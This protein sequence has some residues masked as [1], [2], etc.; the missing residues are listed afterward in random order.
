[1]CIS[2]LWFLVTTENMFQNYEGMVEVFFIFVEGILFM[3]SYDST[4]HSYEVCKCYGFRQH[5]D[6][7]THTHINTQSHK[8][9]HIVIIS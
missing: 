7:H 4:D 6:A 5:A 9:T 3:N 2:T 1:M 8:H